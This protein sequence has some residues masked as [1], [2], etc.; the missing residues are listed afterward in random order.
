MKKLLIG[1]V[2]AL[3][4]TSGASAQQTVDDVTIT[5]TGEVAGNV[6]IE[7]GAISSVNLIDATNSQDVAE[8]V[9]STNFI[10]ESIDVAVTGPCELTSGTNSVDFSVRFKQG[11]NADAAAG[12]LI[13]GPCGSTG[14]FTADSD[15]LDGEIFTLALIQVGNQQAAGTYTGDLTVTVEK[16]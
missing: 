10:G 8:F 7:A 6:G 15:F 9:I 3:A 13:N 12:S 4:V 1:M 2:A 16:P 11:T 5:L 14:S